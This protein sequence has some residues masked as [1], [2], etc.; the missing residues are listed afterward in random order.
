MSTTTPG[1]SASASDSSRG[2]YKVVDRFIN[3]HPTSTSSCCLWG[4]TTAVIPHLRE[5]LHSLD[6]KM[7]TLMS[8]RKEL[9]LHLEQAVRLQSPVQ[10]L[11]SELLSMIFIISVQGIDDGDPVLVSTL[12]LVCRYWADT[13]LN[14]PDLW[15]VISVSTH[16]SL[17][18]ARRKLARSKSVPLDITINFSPR[19]E[20]SSAVTEN[21]VHAMD[22]IRPALWRTRSF[23]LSV[24]NR[25]QAHAALLRCREDAPLLEVLSIRIFHSMQEDHYSSPLLPLFNGHTPRL[26]SCSFTSFNFGWDV[27]VTSR[28]RVLNLGGYFNGFSPSVDTLINVLRECLELEEFALRNM[29]DIDPDTCFPS[30]EE[31]DPH[32]SLQLPRLVKASFYYAG[33]TRIRG[34]LGQISFPA[35]ETLEFC[36]LD[37]LTPVLQHLKTQALTSLPL[38]SLRIE[39]TFFNEMKLIKLLQCLPSL[40]TLELVDVEDASSNL[41]KVR[42]P[43]QPLYRSIPKRINLHRVFPPHRTRSL[44][45]ALNLLF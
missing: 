8:Q 27:R 9:E 18:K 35:L 7:A 17:E 26:R 30:E 5:A 45:S 11:P 21:V 36:Y 12:M 23:R 37:N 4:T 1:V 40:I 19:V 25:P 33:I 2:A 42:I 38:R 44:G 16:D 3:F 14:T 15:S 6:S 10:R 39:S 24:P 32:K 31:I 28:L 34:L 13:A 22:L 41:L 29:S 43:P 20:H